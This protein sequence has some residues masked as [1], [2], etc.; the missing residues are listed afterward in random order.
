MSEPVVRNTERTRR[1]VL[2]AAAELLSQKGA[3]LTLVDVA[4]E[5][6]VSK[7]GLLHHFSSRD[8]LLLEV[9]RDAQS[10]LRSQVLQNLDLSENTPGKMLRAYVRTLCGDDTSLPDLL[11]ATPF[12]LGIEGVPGAQESEA[13]NQLWWNEQLLADGLDPTLVRI[14]RRAAEGLAAGR[15]YGDESADAVRMAGRT[16]VRLTLEPPELPAA[17]GDAGAG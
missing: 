14:V 17:P 7:S 2:D 12:W 11:S 16:L 13:Q 3:G 5:A 6:G 1:A 8:A 10:R 15:A 9:L 4:T